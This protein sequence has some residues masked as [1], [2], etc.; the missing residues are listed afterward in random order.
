M[1]RL[2][3]T[4]RGDRK[5][6]FDHVDAQIDERL[7][8]FQFL[9]EIHT[10]TRRLLAIAQCRV[11]NRYFSRFGHGSAKIRRGAARFESLEPSCRIFLLSATTF[12]MKRHLYAL[13]V[14][15]VHLTQQIPLTREQYRLLSQTD[16]VAL[17]RL[18]LVWS[19]VAPVGI[20]G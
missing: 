6:G 9:L 16:P 10:A 20:D 8:H 4:W 15:K 5:T 3:I 17:V 19:R 7:R 11:K 14:L 1:N 18:V 12:K 13:S 2:E